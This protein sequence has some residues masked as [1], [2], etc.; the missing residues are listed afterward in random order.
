MK[1]KEVNLPAEVL[2]N[3]LLIKWSLILASLSSNSSDLSDASIDVQNKLINQDRLKSKIL[4]VK[5]RIKLQK[6]HYSLLLT[7]IL[8]ELIHVV[9]T[10]K[11]VASEVESNGIFGQIYNEK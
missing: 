5:L 9:N 2:K 10:G 3:K 6:W 11:V 1:E 7:L 8:P 4:K